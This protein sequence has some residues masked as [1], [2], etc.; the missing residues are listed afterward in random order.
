MMNLVPGTPLEFVP[1]PCSLLVR[2]SSSRRVNDAAQASSW[3][4]RQVSEQ[5]QAQPFDPH[6]MILLVVW[7]QTLWEFVRSSARMFCS[8]GDNL[9]HAVGNLS[10]MVPTCCDRSVI[11]AE[12]AIYAESLALPLKMRDHHRRLFLP[13]RTPPLSAPDSLWKS[14][15]REQ[16]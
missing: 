10:K 9:A 12:T 3:D 13:T 15:R 1:S 2:P 11:E 4:K 14:M 7:C 8:R 6:C 16:K 5:Q